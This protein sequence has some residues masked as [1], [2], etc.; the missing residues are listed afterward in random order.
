MQTMWVR[1][2]DGNEVGVRCMM[3]DGDRGQVCGRDGGVDA[4]GPMIRPK[5][6]GRACHCASVGNLPA[7]ICWQEG[8]KA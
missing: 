7:N 6:V 4:G 8:L 1:R 3:T 2:T 5:E